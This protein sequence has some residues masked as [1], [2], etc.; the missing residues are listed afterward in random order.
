MTEMRPEPRIMELREPRRIAGSAV[1]YDAE[2]RR[3]IPA[4]WEMLDPAMYGEPYPTDWYGVC[5]MF[6]EGMRFHYLAGAEVPA[7]WELPEG[8]A[9]VTLPP[10]RY[11]VVEHRGHISELGETWAW[12]FSEWVDEQSGYSLG[13]G[14][15]FELYGREFDPETGE[16]GLEIWFPV[17]RVP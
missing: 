16:G 8:M 2:S 15:Q 10:G 11:A 7:D 12:F 6:E 17:E 3:E 5:Y 14:P 13:Q 1:G 4:Q 9:E